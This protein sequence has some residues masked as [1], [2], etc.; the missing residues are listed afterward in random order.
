M[1]ARKI[2]RRPI[3]LFDMD[4]TLTPSRKPI[5]WNMVKTLVGLSEYADIGIVTGS[6]LNYLSEQCST[7]W[8]EIGSVKTVHLHLLPCNGTQV[9]R[10]LDYKWRQT[11]TRDMRA[12]IGNETY[13][14]LLAYILSAQKKLLTMHNI[15]LPFTGNFVS[16]RQSLLNWCPIGRDAG[17]DER[18]SFQEFDKDGGYRN[19]AKKK[20]EKKL[21]K[22]NIKGIEIALGGQ[23]SLDI[24]PMGWN[25]TFALQHFVGRDVWFVGDRCEE[26][27]ND[28]AIYNAVAVKKEGKAY[29]TA[30]PQETIEII[31]QTIIP[32]LQRS[33]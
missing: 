2:K 26:G 29:W 13:T 6:G 3:V 23:T 28:H 21:N 19:R 33:T 7:L 15:S 30:G 16:Y 1:K 32:H 31:N 22:E 5:K 9:Y 10:Y 17:A 12:E 24:F 4:G 18:A 8:S 11:F 25:K 14:Q 27:G 20:L